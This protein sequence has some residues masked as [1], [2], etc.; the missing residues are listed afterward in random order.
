MIDV[1]ERTPLSGEQRESLATVRY[2]ASALLKIIDDIL[3]FSKIEA[4]RLDLERIELSTVELIEGAAETLAPQ[5]VA[6][7][8]CLTAFVA[9]DAPDRVI[10]DPL[11]LQQILFNLLGNAIKF[12][13][14]GTVRLT[15]ENAGPSMLCIRVVDSGIGLTAEQR[16]RLFQPFVQADASATRRF[17][18]TGLGLALTRRLC[19]LMGGDVAVESAPGRGSTFTIRLPLNGDSGRS[20]DTK[21]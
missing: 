10:G 14:K 6:K 16:E 2:S 13:E 11:R 21:T 18:G 7:G 17:G 5:A 4:G 8:L 12:T 9:A 15:L 20:P 19:R 1:L 3:D